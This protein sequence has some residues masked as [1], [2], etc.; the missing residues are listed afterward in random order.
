MY[1][2][3]N[4]YRLFAIIE[5]IAEVQIHLFKQSY[6]QSSEEQHCEIGREY[7]NR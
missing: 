2:Q 5:R 1:A 6:E 7:G 4:E 3:V